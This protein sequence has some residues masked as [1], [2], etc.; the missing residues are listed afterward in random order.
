MSTRSACAASMTGFIRVRKSQ[1]MA[2]TLWRRALSVALAAI[3]LPA[4]AAQAAAELVVLTD[5]SV[6][7]VTSFAV[8]GDDAK[9]GF[10]RGGT[11]RI[12]MLRVE[13]V[14]DDEVV[15]E[16]EKAAAA[17]EARGAPYEVGFVEGQGRPATAFGDLIFAAGKR[18]G[19]N[20]EL[21]SAV[22]RAESA[23]DARALSRK[24]ARGLMQ[25]MPATAR[26]YGVQPS[27]LWTPER[28]IEAGVRYLAFLK[29]KFDGDLPKILAGYNAGEGAVTRF[30]GIPPYR[31]TQGYVRRIFGY[32]GLPVA[33]L[34]A[35]SPVAGPR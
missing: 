18:H 32:L 22:I 10:V 1:E 5:G 27:E 2:R 30:G 8:D 15:A 14:V 28:N 24:G 21:V 26:R 6:L 16:P 35:S 19:V 25:L 4:L 20:P 3:L 9:L 13:R 31:E 7:K 12:S 23:F 29:R 34:V 11:M 17:L 33:A